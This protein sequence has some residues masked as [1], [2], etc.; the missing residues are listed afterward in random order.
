MRSRLSVA[1]D[2]GR[3]GL[4]GKSPPGENTLPLCLKDGQV[5]DSKQFLVGMSEVGW[6]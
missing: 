6:T 3:L 2:S 5:L 4:T 1:R